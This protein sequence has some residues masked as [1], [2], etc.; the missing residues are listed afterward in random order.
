LGADQSGFTAA[1]GDK[2][3][4]A[5]LGDNATTPFADTAT[6]APKS[7]LS[8]AAN[9]IPAATWTVGG[10]TVSMPVADFYGNARTWPGA[11]GEKKKKVKSEKCEDGLPI[12]WSLSS[13]FHF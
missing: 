7:E 4:A 10:N 13:I 8:N 12:K 3:I 1:T 11:M 2:T 6:L 5:I 9:G